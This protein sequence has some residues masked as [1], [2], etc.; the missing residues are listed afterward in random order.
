MKV[1]L[2]FVQILV[3]LSVFAQDPVASLEGEI[4]DSSGGGV[5]GAS[6]T[7]RNLDTGYRQTQL[8]SAGGFYKLS[9]APVGR[10]ELTVEREGFAKF[11]QQPVQLN[12][13]RTVRLDVNLALASQRQS[14]TVEGDAALVDTASNTLGKVVT[15]KE[16][17]D[18]PLNG[19]NF[20]QLGLLQAGVAPLTGGIQQSGG[21]LRGGQGYA[22]NGQ[23]P[24][25]NIYRIDGATNV[26][27]MD[28]GFALRVPVDAIAEFRILTH[29]APPEY[30]GTSGSTTSV[31]TRSGTNSVHGTLYEFLRNDA[32]DARNFFSTDV[33]PLKQNQFGATA[34]GPLR[35][36]RTFLFGYY[37]GFRNRQGVTRSGVVA[38]GAQRQ[39]DF[40]GQARPLVDLSA[41][42]VPF[43][44]GIIPA[45]RLNPVS[46]GIMERFIPPANAGPSIF[47]STVVTH[48]DYDQGG[49]R[50]DHRFSDADQLAFRY[51]YSQGTNLNPISIRG[52]DLPGFPVADELATN[53]VTLSET[54]LFSPGAVNSFRASFFRHKFYF[55][56]RQNQVSPR[57][58][59]F[60]FD[61]ASAAGQSA[62]LFNIAGYSPVGGAI[63]GP[64]NSVQNDYEIYD[65]VALV[66]G[67]HA[68]K[69]GGDARST[70]ITA[71]QAIAP[72]AFFVFTPSFPSNDGFA[73]FLM[74]RPLVFYQGLGDLSRGLRNWGAGL[75]AQDEW[76][77][78]SRLT[79]NYGVRWE[80]NPPFT[81][82]RDRLNTFV[83]GRQSTV[84]PDAPLGVLFP[85]DEG[86]AKGLAAIQWTGFMPRLGLAWN[87]DGRG[88]FAIRAS[89]G[90]FYDTMSNGQGG[91]FQAPV[92][93]LPW[94]QF[95]Q[96]SGPGTNFVDPYAGRAKPAPDTFMRPST[97]LG[98][99]KDA[100]PPY[101][102]DWN[103]SL[104][105]S[106][107]QNY[108]IEA[109]YVGTKGTH[110]PRNIEANPAVWGPGA[111]P[112]NADRRRIYANCPAD[113]SACQLVHVGL[114]STITN[115]TYHAGQL[116]LSRRFSRGLGLSGSYWFSK[117]LDYLSALNL[118]GAASRPLSGE[119]D[120]AQNPFDLAAEHGP[121]LFD[122]RH[123][124]VMSA[125]WEIPG[126]KS[127]GGA[128]RALLAGWQLNGIAVA[129]SGTPFTVFD[130]ANVAGQASHPPL[131][132]FAA[133]RPDVVSDPNDGPHT[134]EQW[135]SR[136]AFRRLDPLTEAGHFGNA[137]RNIA[138]APGISNLDLSLL[139]NITLGETQRLQ[140][141]A[142]YF[143]A[144]NHTN[145]GLP[146]TDLASPS[147][148]RILDAAPPRLAQF[149]LKLLF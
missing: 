104:Q 88:A 25:S 7:I 63:T 42:G 82:V 70:R 39:G 83:P 74:G 148:G 84:Y 33:E 43:P 4:R 58:L 66:R 121:S 17:L 149:G 6:V 35:R 80:V 133:S 143:N 112:S 94:T 147:F 40:S 106:L 103:F 50:L 99:S 36:D 3:C 145:L 128:G 10:Y 68:L 144:L 130:S 135:I 13:S 49:G 79:V 29:T 19:R 81:E 21:S 75:F 124:F 139:K 51:S 31:V 22:V 114:L 140:F 71:F 34:G 69:F 24:E 5:A 37:E 44:G 12:V 1:R 28:G 137:G 11:Q 93:S 16:V 47:R 87:P 89:Y 26:N 92:S 2:L 120:V 90:I 23:R 48:N 52:S 101:A 127:L 46:L 62:P 65:A 64:R 9:M 45:S 118:T 113:G 117:S 95:M 54:H 105:R 59:G 97:V 56:Q 109:R 77:V 76:R 41:G 91:A 55:D 119:V 98:T 142:E 136:S 110:L 125:S 132:G 108:V 85:G 30:G 38:T 146:V 134:V 107:G 111:T 115:S 15:R 141:R 123:R 32:L 67:K 72:N 86:V 78:T 96:L 138:R 73:N 8:S 102:Q 131:S 116:T 53:A 61:S 27:R 57:E 20:T 14:V 60:N 126:P 129:S 18:L 122:A 100:R